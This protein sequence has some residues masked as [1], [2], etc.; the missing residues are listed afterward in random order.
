MSKQ[1]KISDF[2]QDDRNFNRHTEAGMELLKKSIETVGV[3]EA[4]TVS[5]DD[6]IISG[7]ARQENFSEVLGDVEPIVVDI[8]GS[9]PVVLRRT[10]IRSGTK[11]YHEA[12]LLANTTAKQNINLDIDLIQE[13]A[14][15]EFD[16]DIVELGVDFIDTSDVDID[17]FFKQDDTKKE[18]TP[19]ICPNCGTKISEK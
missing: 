13:I 14:V 2:T 5:S 11:R 1:I 12:A 18:K 16:I 8:D 4:V 10:D 17:A 19:I 15:E 7:N 9:R 3:I 6:R